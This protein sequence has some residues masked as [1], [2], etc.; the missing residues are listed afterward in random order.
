MYIQLK[1]PLGATVNKKIESED[2]EIQLDQRIVD[3]Y[4]DKG[5]LNIFNQDR[6]AALDSFRCY[7]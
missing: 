5:I 4:G 2:P 3:T 6:K 7:W 1:I